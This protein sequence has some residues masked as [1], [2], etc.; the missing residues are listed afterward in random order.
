MTQKLAA[1]NL[2]QY[3]I[4]VSDMHEANLQ[5]QIMYSTDLEYQRKRYDEKKEGNLDERD[6]PAELSS[7]SKENERL[8]G[9]LFRYRA[10][11]S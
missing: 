3:R 6:T 9:A 10:T 4:T 2:E 7:L 1:E 8:D 11:V 5:L